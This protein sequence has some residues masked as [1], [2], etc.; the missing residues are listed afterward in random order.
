MLSG[1]WTL[2]MGLSQQEMEICL[3]T[4]LISCSEKRRIKQ[5]KNRKRNT[6]NENVIKQ[7]LNI[8]GYHYDLH[9]SKSLESIS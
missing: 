5:T 6:E 9:V 8:V 3:I 7:N 4:I 2:L 1:S